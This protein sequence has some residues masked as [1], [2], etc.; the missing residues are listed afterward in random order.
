[1]VDCLVIG[2]LVGVR[3]TKEV[4]S[5][6]SLFWRLWTPIC[7]EAWAAWMTDMGGALVLSHVP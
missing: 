7:Q 4:W 2:Y 1:M 5:R 6:R 3:D